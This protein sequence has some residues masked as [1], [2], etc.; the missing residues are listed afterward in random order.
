MA[1]H[2]RRFQFRLPH[3]LSPLSTCFFV[4]ASFIFL[5][6]L[7]LAEGFWSSLAANVLIRVLYELVAGSYG[8][9]AHLFGN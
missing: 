2:Q 4:T 1:P 8:A 3:P 6:L 7:R 5:R 9:P